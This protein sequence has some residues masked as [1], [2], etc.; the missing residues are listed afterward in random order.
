METVTINMVGRFD[1]LNM[2]NT[3]YKDT[4]PVFQLPVIVLLVLHR[5]MS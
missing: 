5:L 3:E 4:Y 2:L 1:S